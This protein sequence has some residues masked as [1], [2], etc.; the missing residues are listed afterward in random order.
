[1]VFVLP[2]R[3]G[4]KTLTLEAVRKHATAY[5]L[6]SMKERGGKRNVTGTGNT[7]NIQGRRSHL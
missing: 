1:M 5:L 2:K 7:R 3:G 6:L 4:K